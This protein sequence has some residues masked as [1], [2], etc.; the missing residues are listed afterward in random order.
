ML[1]ITFRELVTLRRAKAGTRGASNDPVYEIVRDT[2]EE[3]LKVRCYIERRKRRVFSTAG[4]EE[5]SDATMLFRA[6]E[7]ADVRAEDLVVDQDG[8]AYRVNGL[9]TASSL[10]GSARYRRADLRKTRLK[11]QEGTDG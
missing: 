4:V 1:D 3:P 9:E 7:K 10:F 6:T 11:V 8:A 5:E 2:A